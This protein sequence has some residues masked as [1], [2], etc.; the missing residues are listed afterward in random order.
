MGVD[1]KSEIPR[2]FGQAFE[3]T[4]RGRVVN[5]V[6]GRKNADGDGTNGHA[7]QICASDSHLAK[8]MNSPTY[9]LLHWDELQQLQMSMSVRD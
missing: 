2:L 6:S 4:F 9:N 7:V 8:G 3:S 1:K 5:K